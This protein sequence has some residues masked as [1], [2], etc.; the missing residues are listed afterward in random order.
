MI[1]GVAECAETNLNVENGKENALR[2]LRKLSKLNKFGKLGT[3]SS[4]C[5]ILAVKSPQEI[6]PMDIADADIAA[7][8]KE[9]V[10]SLVK[11]MPPLELLRIA[12]MS[13]AE[14]L[15][16]ASADTLKRAH[17]DKIIKLSKRREGMRVVHALM[18]RDA[19]R[20]T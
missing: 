20:A 13:E 6:T 9:P 7:L 2:K 16:G 8:L 3:L 17:P 15:S 1:D 12:P 18:L 11:T 10:A 4:G 19:A 5:E 14:H